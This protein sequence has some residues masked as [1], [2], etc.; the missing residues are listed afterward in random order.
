MLADLPPSIP[1]VCTIQTVETSWSHQPIA[2]I[3]ELKHQQFV[4]G[5]GS[6]PVIEPRTVVDSRIT[7]LV[8]R[9]SSSVVDRSDPLKA[10]YQWTFTA[11]LG[12]L[13]WSESTLGE[14]RSSDSTVIVNGTLTIHNRATFELNQQSRLTE[15]NGTR[16]LNTLQESAQG[17]CLN[18]G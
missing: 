18:Q 7:T 5:G 4:V 13:E 11:P 17:R 16:T 2:G 3:R 10:T 8:D 12:L 6:E 14:G 9:F 1:L 15:A